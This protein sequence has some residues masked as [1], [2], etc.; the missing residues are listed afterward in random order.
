M[1]TMLS[2]DDEDDN[3]ND[4]NTEAVTSIAS[5]LRPQGSSIARFY[6]QLA[7]KTPGK[8]VILSLISEYADSYIPTTLTSDFPKPLSEL[9]DA[10]TL[11]LTFDELLT[12]CE[13]VYNSFTI[14][15]DEA[16]VVEANARK[17]AKC[18]ISKSWK[19]HGIKI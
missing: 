1:K 14:T 19:S 11:D 15:R 18:G 13:D 2:T 7:T 17:Q 12:K 3:Y 16:K 4:V 9:F 10:S 8:P 6:R 5:N